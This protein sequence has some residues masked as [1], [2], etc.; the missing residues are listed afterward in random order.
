MRRVDERARRLLLAVG[1][2]VVL[3]L[4][5]PR[6]GWDLIGWVGLAPVLWLAAT[7]RSPGRAFVEAGLAGLAFFVPLL[8]WLIHTMTTYSTLPRPVAALVLVALSAYLALY[9]GGV[10]WAVAWLRATLGPAAL[11]LAPAFWVAGEL[12][13]THLLSG[14]PWGLLGYIPYRRL[15]LIQVAAWTGVYGVSGLMV[16]VNTA[17]AWFL[18]ART[19]QAM[20]LGAA[21]ILVVLGGTLAVGRASVPPA[22]SDTIPVAIIQGNIDQSIKWNRAYQQETL[23]IYAE[24]TR[25]AA[26]G[27]RLV[28]WPEA[29]VPAYLLYEPWVL[30]WL[31]DLAGEVRA[32]LLVGAPD[33]R[34][35]GRATRYLNSAFFVGQAGV[36]ARYDKMQLV[37]FGEYVPLKGLLFFVE[38][39][40]AEIGDFT[41]GRERVIFPLQGTPF[42]AVICYEVIFPDLFRQ[43]VVEGASFMVNITNDAWFGDSG[44][45]L[46]H[47]AMV[48]LR[49][50]ENGVAIVRAANT[51]VSTL[52]AP[53]GRIGPE[54]G[55]FRRGFL[56]VEVPRRAGETFY[57]RAGNLFAYLM[58]ALAAAALLG[59]LGAARVR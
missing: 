2:G 6:P 11:W 58:S 12:A 5:Y 52:V 32:P 47:L 21:V 43:F 19:R 55:L 24:L 10:A 4:A 15:E 35:E 14:F 54:L 8:R 44:G 42:G 25:R 41:P 29:A 3:H 37:P 13:R 16:L 57:T 17:L 9:W 59:R 27:M 26:P 50:V 53:S 20:A 28:V 56:Q 33:A 48:P 40:A 23:R 22:G 45:P 34:R 46:Q 38:A 30:G 31:T 7:A 49:A 51:G 1:A 36:Q 18:L 39:I